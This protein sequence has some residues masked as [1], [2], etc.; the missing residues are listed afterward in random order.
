MASTPAPA[1]EF[2]MGAPPVTLPQSSPFDQFLNIVSQVS[3]HI[4]E[5]NHQL[6]WPEWMV[7]TRLREAFAIFY[8]HLA[9]I[10]ATLELYQ[11][12]NALIEVTQTIDHYVT[13]TLN[14]G[15]IHL[16]CP[17]ILEI[18]EMIHDALSAYCQQMS[19]FTGKITGIELQLGWTIA[20]KW[21]RAMTPDGY[22]AHC[23]YA[24]CA[25]LN[26]IHMC[27]RCIAHMRATDIADGIPSI[28][29]RAVAVTLF[30]CRDHRPVDGLVEWFACLALPASIIESL[31]SGQVT[32]IPTPLGQL[33]PQF[34]VDASLRKLCHWYR[35][36]RF[37][38]S[39]CAELV[40]V[41]IFRPTRLMMDTRLKNP[42][43]IGGFQKYHNC[44]FLS[45][46]WCLTIDSTQNQI[47]GDYTY[48]LDGIVRQHCIVL[49]LA[50]LNVEGLAS[51]MHNSSYEHWYPTEA[52]HRH[53][54][55]PVSCMQ[56]EGVP[57]LMLLSENCDEIPAD[58]IAA[59]A[60]LGPGLTDSGSSSSS[61][62]SQEYSVM[63][64]TAA[65]IAQ[66]KRKGQ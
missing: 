30:R 34:S 5:P 47:G 33:N 9:S 41:L 52:V 39:Q 63:V 55:F 38:R 48:C 10:A 13:V 36:N 60:G 65:A 53:C 4:H 12:K 49:E 7:L 57:E 59:S 40:K 21:S 15:I 23:G 8:V 22:S 62:T 29:A 2:I 54:T 51:L 56:I 31:V 46:S 32:N 37:S 25:F 3:D 17:V 42:E 26:L 14:E 19:R 11:W 61:L 6:R 58:D 45:C 1:P 20:N 16:D 18:A 64:A 28:F 66:K 24:N 44:S 50:T 27:N 35:Q 43:G